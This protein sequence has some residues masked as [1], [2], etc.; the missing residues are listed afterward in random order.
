MKKLSALYLLSA[1]FTLY[2]DSEV[3]SFNRHIRP[4]LSDAC[5]ACHG[6]DANQREANLRLDTKEGAFAELGGYYAIIP[7][8]PSSSKLIWRITHP[9]VDQRMPPPDSNRR[10]PSEAEIELIEKWIKQG[11][12]WEDHWIYTPPQRSTLPEIKHKEWPLTPIDHFINRWHLGRRNL[13]WKRR[14]CPPHA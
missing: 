10:Y 12:K 5:Y 4:I 3:V 7:G 9:D 11:A 1:L 13:R 2:A 14:R 8:D 6:P